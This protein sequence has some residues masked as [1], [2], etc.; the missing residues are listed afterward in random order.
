M[1]LSKLH[2]SHGPEIH[3]RYIHCGREYYAQIENDSALP[4][5]AILR[6]QEQ[7]RVVKLYFYIFPTKSYHDIKTKM[8]SIEG[9]R[10]V[11]P[12]MNYGHS[13][14]TAS[15]QTVLM[16]HFGLSLPTPRSNMRNQHYPASSMHESSEF[17]EVSTSAVHRKPELPLS[18]GRRDVF[19]RI[20][21]WH[22]LQVDDTETPFIQPA[23]HIP[24]PFIKRYLV[25][26]VFCLENLQM[27][28][29]PFDPS[30]STD[31]SF[32]L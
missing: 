18:G 13:G 21:F 3:I 31:D 11:G 12:H 16:V 6:N 23:Y 26:I 5:M 1:D 19:S 22:M 7:K 17:E 28:T 25:P 4:A 20:D 27:T 14:I 9:E 30:R 2:G 32:R 29:Q 8:H 15:R 10:D 24:I